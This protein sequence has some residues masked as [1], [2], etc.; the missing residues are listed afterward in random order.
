ME[1]RLVFMVEAT[2]RGDG[3]LKVGLRV[4]GEMEKLAE[5]LLAVATQSEDVRF[6]FESVAE[7]LQVNNLVEEVAESISE[8]QYD[9]D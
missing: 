3:S 5:M 4:E 2:P 7:A 6:L 8:V 1:D 9:K